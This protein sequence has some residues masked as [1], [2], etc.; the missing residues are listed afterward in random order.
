MFVHNDMYY[1]SGKYIALQNN[2]S[3]RIDPQVKT[4]K[5]KLYLMPWEFPVAKKTAL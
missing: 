1:R 2:A 4:A 5:M 3:L